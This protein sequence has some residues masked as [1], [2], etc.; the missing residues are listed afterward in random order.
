MPPGDFAEFSRVLL[1]SRSLLKVFTGTN[2]YVWPQPPM[3]EFF[4]YGRVI[5]CFDAWSGQSQ[6][7][8]LESMVA[9]CTHPR[10]VW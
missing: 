10:G 6:A 7:V 1:L 9:V 8:L 2:I 4:D 5:P 3:A